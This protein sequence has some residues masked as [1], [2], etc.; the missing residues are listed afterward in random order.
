MTFKRQLTIKIGARFDR[1]QGLSTDAP[2]VDSQFRDTG[3][4][5]AGL[6]TVIRWNTLSP[7]IGMNLKLN[8]DG[9]MVLR[10]LAGRYY[11]S[12]TLTSIENVHPGV[13]I[14]T[15][16]RFDPAT[17]GY[18]NIISVTDPRANLA[19]KREGLAR[20]DAVITT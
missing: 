8:D 11:D 19:A 5:I 1:L 18:T 9:S 14:T 13:A 7:R 15:L 16:A 20:A 6:G 4:T 3:V 10:G 12:I 17:N 2:A